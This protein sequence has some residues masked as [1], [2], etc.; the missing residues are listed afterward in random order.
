MVVPALGSNRAPRDF[1][2]LLAT[3]HR[4]A[5]FMACCWKRILDRDE[6]SVHVIVMYMNEMVVE[7]G[8]PRLY[9]VNGSRKVSWRR[10]I[11]HVTGP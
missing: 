8:G 7:V 4:R 3:D 9:G 6:C 11:V 10:V 1:P 2:K 5:N